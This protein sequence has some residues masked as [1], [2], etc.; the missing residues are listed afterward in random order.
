M[1]ESMA[2]SLRCTNTISTTNPN[3][4]TIMAD[5]TRAMTFASTTLGGMPGSK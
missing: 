5:P 2:K 4:N 3:N 1:G